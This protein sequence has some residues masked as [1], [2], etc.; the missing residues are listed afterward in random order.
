MNRPIKQQQCFLII[1]I[2]VTQD[3][4]AD[5]AV[6]PGLATSQT[7]LISP[8]DY[9]CAHAVASKA[10]S[11]SCL[12][13][14]VVFM[15]RWPGGCIFAAHRLRPRGARWCWRVGAA[16]LVHPAPP[17]LGGCIPGVKVRMGAAQDMWATWGGG[18]RLV[19]PPRLDRGYGPELQSRRRN[20][21]SGK[22]LCMSFSVTSRLSVTNWRTGA[23][24]NELVVMLRP[25][26]PPPDWSTKTQMARTAGSL[27]YSHDKLRW[28]HGAW[29]AKC[30]PGA[31]TALATTARWN[32]RAAGVVVE[33][34]WSRVVQQGE[35]EARC[36]AGESQ[37]P[38]TTSAARLH[39]A[40]QAKRPGMGRAIIL[41][42]RVARR[43]AWAGRAADAPG[44]SI[45]QVKLL[46][47]AQGAAAF[48]HGSLYNA[49]RL[50]SAP[51]SFFTHGPARS[52]NRMLRQSLA[53]RH[54]GSS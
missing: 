47:P 38:A 50:S 39:M 25:R 8:G 27:E 52:L 11:I 46:P 6:G 10:A 43:A 18:Q 49:G 48:L 14:A 4:T 15:L 7:R 51:G 24:G 40:M 13:T 19:A 29:P 3:Y 30:P 22:R 1:I 53:G 31:T 21:V 34:W 35:E 9:W 5:S 44:K 20:G 42:T 12:P 17:L 26:R 28:F 45:H 41:S 33:G 16:G 37:N 23:Q 32:M 36:G 54:H 2:I